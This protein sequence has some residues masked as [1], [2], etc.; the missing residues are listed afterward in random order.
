MV[1]APL[2]DQG[3]S[4]AVYLFDTITGRQVNKYMAFDT[5]EGGHFGSS[6][7]IDRRNLLIG[8]ESGY[9]ANER[10]AVYFSGR[11]KKVTYK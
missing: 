10:G 2:H 5:V 4:G 3:E 1:S 9:W 6:V 7:A 8:A 11:C